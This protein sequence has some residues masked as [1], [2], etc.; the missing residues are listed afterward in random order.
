[1]RTRTPP[2]GLQALLGLSLLLVPFP[3]LALDL[4][5]TVAES[6]AGWVIALTSGCALALGGI[7]RMGS[8]AQE[9][10]LPLGM[11]P[12][13]PLGTVAILFLAVGLLILAPALVSAAYCQQVCPNSGGGPPNAN[14]TESCARTCGVSGPTSGILAMPFVSLVLDVIGY[15]L[16]LAA[17]RRSWTAARERS[18]QGRYY[19]NGG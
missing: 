1:M 5:Q 8:S 12:G 18:G 19:P 16:L 4:G 17:V 7:A 11:R 6:L 9:S 10:P 13:F 2:G 15:V 3:I 14:S